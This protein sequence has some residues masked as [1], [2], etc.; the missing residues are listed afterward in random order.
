MAMRA[1]VFC[2][3]SFPSPGSICNCDTPASLAILPLTWLLMPDASK[4]CAP[5]ALGGLGLGF[6]DADSTVFPVAIRL[7]MS[8]GGKAGSEEY[9]GCNRS[10]GPLEP[11][12]M[13]YSLLLVLTWR[14]TSCAVRTGFRK[15]IVPWP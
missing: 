8:T 15:S 5:L 6:A 7:M 3:L 12:V 14:L 13:L 4:D 10:T 11:S 2:P 1:P 9:D